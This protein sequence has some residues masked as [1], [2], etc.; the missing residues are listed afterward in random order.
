MEKKR[1]LYTP[2]EIADLLRVKPVTVHLWLR[3]GKLKG[4][5]V[6]GKLWRSTRRQLQEFLGVDLDSLEKEAS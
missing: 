5:K 1:L 6:G 4:F 2:E 3:N